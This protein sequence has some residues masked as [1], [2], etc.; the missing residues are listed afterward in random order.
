MKANTVPVV[1]VIQALRGDADPRVREEVD[2]TLAIL[3]GG[4]ALPLG[5]QSGKNP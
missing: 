5:G 1:A 2:Q 4:Q 3:L